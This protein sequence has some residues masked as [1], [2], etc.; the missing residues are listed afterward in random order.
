MEM[1][2]GEITVVQNLRKAIA[3][4]SG[5][6]ATWL[7]IPL[8]PTES[9]G[10]SPLAKIPPFSSSWSLQRSL[11]TR[12]CVRSLEKSGRSFDAA[13]FNAPS[14]AFFLRQ[15]RHR[16]PFVS[17]LDATPIVLARYGY[18]K[19]R[20]E[21]NPI[22]R[23][24]RHRLTVSVFKDAAHLLAYSAFIKE[25]L[26]TDYGIKEDKISIVPPGVD[27][28]IWSRHT[29][30]SPRGNH[31]SGRLQVLFV[32]A[33]FARKGGD[34]LLSIA[35]RKDFQLCDFHFVT[36]NSHVPNEKNIFI[37]ANMKA[38]SEPLRALYRQSDIFV[39]P[40][41]A[42][43]S[44]NVI[45]E[46]MAMELPVLSTSVGGIGEMVLDGETGF[47]VAVDDEIAIC[48]RLRLLIDDG[49]LRT[50][51]GSNGRRLVESKFNLE[52]N[53][54]TIVKY[55]GKAADAKRT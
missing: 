3:G 35:R 34:L 41:R 25:S 2:E 12:S 8:D 31:A 47:I 46:A 18:Y 38:N 6:E 26:V 28:G 37:H 39:L 21:A 27:L 36:P 24:L 51:L 1:A 44:P 40:T 22:V 48:D 9:I 16:T 23:Q 55:L 32:G 29:M 14:P 30:N 20:A 52:K 11:L 43:F 50:R 54:E 17:A 53:A 13:Y 7:P 4:M 19:P 5:I 33:N 10:R 42:D 15:F 45:C 49:K